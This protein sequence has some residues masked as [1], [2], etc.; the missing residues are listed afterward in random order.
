MQDS[1]TQE[2]PSFLIPWESSSAF[3]QD[4]CFI[5]S[6]I[7]PNKTLEMIDSGHDRLRGKLTSKLQRTDCTNLNTMDNLS[8][9]DDLCLSESEEDP[10]ASSDDSNDSDYRPE[11]KKKV[12][13]YNQDSGSSDSDIQNMEIKKN[14]RKRLRNPSKWRRNEIKRLRNL[15][16][17]YKDWKGNVHPKRQLKSACTSCRQKCNDKFSEEERKQ[18]FEN[19]WQLGDVNRQR[20]FITKQVDMTEKA[21]TRLR[22]QNGDSSDEEV[23]AEAK[24]ERKKVFS[25]KYTF[26]NRGKRTAV[27]KTFFLNTLGISAQVVKTVFQ[28][29]GSTG[30]V[31]EDRR[32]RVCK[33]SKLSDSVKQS[34]RDHINLFETVESHY[35]RK[36]TSKRFLPPTLNVSKM[37]NMYLEYC[38]QSN[39]KPAPECTYRVIFNTEFNFSFFIPKK[40]LCDICHRYDEGTA[41]ARSEMEEHYQL[42]MINKDTGRQL[43]NIDKE[44]AKLNSDFCAAVFDLEQVLPT[45]KSNVGIT[46]Y[47]LK[48]STYNFTIFNLAS[49][50]GYCY[51]W[52]ESI[53]K[54]GSSEIGSCLLRFIEHKVQQGTKQFSFY[55]DNCAGQNRNRFIFSMYNFLAQKYNIVIRHTFLEKGHTQT[56]GD[57]MHSVVERAARHVPISIPDQWYTLVRTA[58]RIKPFK[59]TEMEKEDIFDLK[60]LTN[61]T[62]LNWDRDENNEKIIITNIK[63]LEA[64]Y[65]IPNKIHFK[66]SYNEQFRTV[67]LSTRG[68][69]K[70]NV[71]INQIQLRQCYM[72]ALPITKKKYNHLQYLCSKEAIPVR[73]HHFY[74]NLLYSDTSKDDSD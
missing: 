47:K 48:L 19:Y 55:S 13:M 45:P 9:P 65:E 35:C 22:K 61:D 29:M 23:E 15:G 73:H 52:Y 64:N 71:D 14:T 6:E 51:M 41:E 74:K 42:H 2:T 24:R 59:V 20:D 1:V 7:S 57:S 36:N 37:Y 34:V 8:C 67:D 72:G 27:C 33:N 68:R 12:G 46:F 60:A 49:S 44:K 56:E 16:Q 70:I 30:I 69:R 25:F 18:I 26:Y 32:G 4:N 10:F 66:Y 54:R 53:A 5:T 28:K 63:V 11:L 3:L 17:K 21:R 40:D 38:E 62:T 31:G 39:I 58:K 50:E 43:K